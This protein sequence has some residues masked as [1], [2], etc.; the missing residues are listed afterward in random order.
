MC[1]F[2]LWEKSYNDHDFLATR[3]VIENKNIVRKY[4]TSAIVSNFFEKPVFSD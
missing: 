2:K 3:I 4:A 1:I